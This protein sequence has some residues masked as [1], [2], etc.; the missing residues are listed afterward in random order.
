[1]GA[2]PRDLMYVFRVIEMMRGLLRLLGGTEAD[3]LNIMTS[4]AI[5]LSFA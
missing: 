4:S 5:K 1:M 3:R 2:L